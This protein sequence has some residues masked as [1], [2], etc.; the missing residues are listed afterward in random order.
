[1]P[2]EMSL[3]LREPEEVRIIHE[4][5]GFHA[6]RETYYEELIFFDGAVDR[7]Q[8]SR[9]LSKHKVN[10][11]SRKTTNNGDLLINEYGLLELVTG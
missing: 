6:V 11:R 1:M 3:L 4:D 7:L 8:W 2:N 5:G 9:D 10:D